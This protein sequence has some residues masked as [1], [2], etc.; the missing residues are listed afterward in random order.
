ML[1]VIIFFLEVFK[2]YFNKHYMANIF[3]SSFFFLLIKE[4]WKHY[5]PMN[6]LLD[7]Q[8]SQWE[9]KW[10]PKKKNPGSVHG[11]P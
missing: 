2:N 4:A 8:S 11:R 7:W 3:L 5:G 6:S 10:I 1:Y 9:E